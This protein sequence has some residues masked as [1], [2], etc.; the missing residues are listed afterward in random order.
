MYSHFTD[1]RPNCHKEGAN[2]INH[3]HSRISVAT[4]ERNIWNKK[5]VSYMHVYIHSSTIH[6]GQ[7]IEAT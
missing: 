3:E 2:R 1:N 7:N 4:F 6:S 5:Y